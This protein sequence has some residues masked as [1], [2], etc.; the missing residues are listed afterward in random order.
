VLQVYIYFT[1]PQPTQIINIINYLTQKRQT[2]N[3]KRGRE[4]EIEEY[5]CSALWEEAKQSHG[6]AQRERSDQV[7]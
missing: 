3:K 6:Q 7:L 5:H 1:L 2:S 4:I